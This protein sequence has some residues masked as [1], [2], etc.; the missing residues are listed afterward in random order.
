MY[1]SHDLHC[2]YVHFARACLE[3]GQVHVSS[4]W[5]LAECDNYIDGGVKANN[6]TVFG[7]TEIQDYLS[8]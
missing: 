7:I 2:M 1:V 4:S 3:G 5:F 8:K 6:P